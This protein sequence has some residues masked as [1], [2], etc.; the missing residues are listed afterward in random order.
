MARQ[1]VYFELQLTLLMLFF[2]GLSREYLYEVQTSVVWYPCFVTMWKWDAYTPLN[3]VHIT[4]HEQN[5]LAVCGAWLR[6]LSY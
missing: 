2:T 6:L 3:A 5:K 1:D 4:G